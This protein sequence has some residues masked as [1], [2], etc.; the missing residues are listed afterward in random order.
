M[1]RLTSRRLTAIALASALLLCEG[2]A[3]AQGFIIPELGARKNGTG[4]AIG[5][6]DDLSAIYHNPAALTELPG[7]RVGISLGLAFLQT[8]VRMAPWEGSD[9]YIKDP[10]DS[11]GYYPLI[12]PLVFAPI[13]F[14]GIST[15]LWTDKLVAAFG[16][17]VPN[18]AGA[19]FGDDKA[20]R[21]HIVDAYVLSAFFTLAV[22]YRPVE[23]LS[24]GLGASA[25][26]V[27]INRNSYL[28]PV[29]NGADQSALLG[30]TTKMEL[31]GEDVVP[32]FNLGV[33][34][35]PHRALT[36]GLMA[37]SRYDMELEG[38]LILSSSDP[39]SLL[40]SEAIKSKLAGTR[41]KTEISAPW[42]VGFGVNWDIAP[43]LEVGAEFRYYI[44]Q[45]I[46][47]QRTTI[48]E[49]EMLKVM[50]PDGLVTTKDLHNSVHTG[51]GL[52]IKPLYGL[53][54]DLDLMTGFHYETTSTPNHTM[55]ISA[56][57]FDLAAVHGGLRYT[58]NKRYAISLI[59]SHYWYFERTTSN[60]IT[61][62]P[63]NFVGSGYTNQATLVVEARLGDGI[64][65]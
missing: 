31:T 11:D 37:L 65:M 64:G 28:F 22:A 63:T 1:E 55:E 34:L 39:S 46:T 24:V 5:R 26:Y 21:Y 41:Q 30:G 56:P 18:A 57:T 53:G 17:Y 49:G 43:Y 16:F 33:Q 59:Y 25:V 52:V 38:P 60:S 29:I 14:L 3:A 19:T 6:P 42:I 50:L 54:I 40:S 13:P 44:N 20:S 8:N 2:T 48:T 45:H 27:R 61:F 36:I 58:H 7:V 35:R 12:D 62:P 10:V 51:A 4:A 15:N 32:A 9:K 23:W 47:E